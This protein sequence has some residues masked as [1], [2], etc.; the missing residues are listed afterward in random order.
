MESI[1]EKKYIIRD[2][3][4]YRELEIFI[5]ELRKL[6]NEMEISINLTD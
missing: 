3:S 2:I 6:L 1:I 5:N 4:K